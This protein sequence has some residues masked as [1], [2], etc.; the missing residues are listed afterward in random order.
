MVTATDVLNMLIENRKTISRSYEHVKL[1]FTKSEIQNFLDGKPGKDLG[2][3]TRNHQVKQA[4]SAIGA[5]LVDQKI[6]SAST[7][8]TYR[9][10]WA[11][12]R[13]ESCKFCGKPFTFRFM[14]GNNGKVCNKAKCLLHSMR[15]TM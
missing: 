1:P 7:V 12:D 14:M 4:V 15:E 11:I 6:A 9:A 13:T 8:A 2:Y 3:T 10:L 5:C